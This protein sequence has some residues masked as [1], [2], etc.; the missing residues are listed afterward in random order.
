MECGSQ[1]YNSPTSPDG[2]A[3]LSWA[4]SLGTYPTCILNQTVDDDDADGGDGG[5]EANEQK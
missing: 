5:G 4:H 2:W 1:V 3:E